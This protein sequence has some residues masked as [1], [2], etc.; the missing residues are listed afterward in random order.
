M[1]ILKKKIFGR[2]AEGFVQVQADEPEDM[3]HLYNLICEGDLITASTI[4]NVVKE[5][6]TGSTVKNRVKMVLKIAVERVE[7]DAE[8][9]SLRVNGKNV[10]EN[11]HVKLGQYHTIDLEMS[12]P[13]SIEKT[14]WDSIFIERLNEAC[15]PGQKAEVA[16]VVMQE[17]LANVCLVT[18]AMT[19][20]KVKIERNIPRKMTINQAHDKARVRFFEEVYEAIQRH[21]N[22]DVIKVVIVGSPGFVKDDFM[23]FLVDKAT[24][25]GDT[26]TCERT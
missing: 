17:G 4:R 8:Q 16:V 1:R 18:S 23:K 13:F 19:I 10:E 6:N 21:V 24:R 12:R 20:T 2:N 26:G 22:F 25:V 3:Y 15:D 9:C 14:C 7:F 5:T 11:E